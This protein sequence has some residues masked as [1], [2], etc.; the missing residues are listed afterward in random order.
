MKHALFH[1]FS[2]NRKGLQRYDVILRSFLGKS[3]YKEVNTR[4]LP[5][6][7]AVRNSWTSSRRIMILKHEDLLANPENLP[8]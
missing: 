8:M 2:A 3:K 6:Y 7:G 1:L 4:N 5:I